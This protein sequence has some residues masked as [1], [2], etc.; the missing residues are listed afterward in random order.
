MTFPKVRTL[1]PLAAQLIVPILPQAGRF[2]LKIPFRLL[3]SLVDEDLDLAEKASA[4][5]PPKFPDE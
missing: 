4:G 2:F 5:S 3:R 1:M